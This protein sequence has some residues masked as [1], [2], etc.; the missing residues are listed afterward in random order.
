MNGVNGSFNHLIDQ[1]DR[2]LERI[3]TTL[4]RL[5]DT[6]DEKHERLNG[7]VRELESKA[8]EVRGG[9]TALTVVGA[10]AGTLGGL[11]SKWFSWG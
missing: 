1:L 3:E 9:W 2:R 10:V 6:A 11:A 5:V 7:R 8:S 4:D